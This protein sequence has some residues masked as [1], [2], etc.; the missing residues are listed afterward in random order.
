MGTGDGAFAAVGTAHGLQVRG[1]LTEVFEAEAELAVVRRVHVE[2]QDVGHG[3]ALCA[4]AVAVAAHVAVVRAQ[5][6][7]TG[8][9]HLLVDGAERRG[10]GTEVLVELIHVGDAGDRRTDVGIAQHPFQR[11]Q[12]AAFAVQDS[13][14]ALAIGIVPERAVATGHHLHGDYAEACVGGELD[15]IVDGWSHGEV[16]GGEQDIEVILASHDG[17]HQLFLPTV[18]ADAGET[19]FAGFLRDLLRFEEF[20]LEV[21]RF[22]LGVEV[23]DVHVVGADF[24]E[25]GV[26][27][28]EGLLFS[29]CGALGGEENLVA[30]GAQGSAHHALAIAAL[31]AAG[32]IEIVDAKVGGAFDHRGIGRDH[33]AKGDGGYF[34]AGLAQHAV[35]EFGRA[36]QRRRSDGRFCWSLL[37]GGCQKGRR[38]KARHQEH[39][40]RRILGHELVLKTEI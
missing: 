22:T 5:R 15:G 16:V 35:V 21:L 39:S 37:P 2:A 33:G 34:E 32:G 27:I 7:Q 28:G 29:W 30:A 11:G 4:R 25:A 17:G 24:A 38:T 18:G 1:E 36:P 40:S 26:Q 10:H 20:V 14:D 9:E 19:D 6:F 12:R 13:L 8:F 23:P 3:Q 31:I